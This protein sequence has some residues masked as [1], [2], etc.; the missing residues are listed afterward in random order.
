M[1]LSARKGQKGSVCGPSHMER[2][3]MLR[4][5]ECCERDNEF[6]PVPKRPFRAPLHHGMGG[7]KRLELLE[8]WAHLHH[9][10]IPKCMLLGCCKVIARGSW[11]AN[12]PALPKHTKFG[13]FVCLRHC[14]AHGP[15]P[16]FVLLKKNFLYISLF[17]CACM[18]MQRSKDNW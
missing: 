11:V 10:F 2:L 6:L 3:Q 17:V 13:G 18:C 5:C 16:A 8:N 7:P 14:S 12:A 1:W 9:R 4:L 15:L